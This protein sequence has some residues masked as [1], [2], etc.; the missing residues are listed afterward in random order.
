MSFSIRVS[1]P[2]IDALTNG[3]IDQ[4]AL[5]ADTDNIL[6]KEQSRG[7]TVLPFNSIATINHDL[8]YIPMFFVYAE[9]STGRYRIS[10]NFDPVGGGWRSYAGTSNLYIE[11]RFG[12]TLGA[13]YYTFYDNVG[14][15]I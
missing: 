1:L 6:I 10:N 8:S 2:G 11:N 12:G 3:T 5:Y 15:T 4:Y 14:G 9:I 13:T 7:G